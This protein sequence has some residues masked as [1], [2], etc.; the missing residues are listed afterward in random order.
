MLV[1]ANMSNGVVHFVVT[2][3]LDA[4]CASVFSIVS[5]PRRR[6][7]WQSSLRSVELQTPGPARLGTRWR[8][9]TRAG[10]GFEMEITE[11]EEPTRWSERGSGRMA[12]AHLQVEFEATPQGTRLRV[13]VDIAFK[14]PF[15][16]LAPVVRRL[17]PGALSADIRR[18]GKLARSAPG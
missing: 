1:V 16:L 18:V 4:S 11:F 7:E 2:E 6:L 5:D 12:D 10:P 15:Q 8:E 3:T 14:G 9:V 13:T 17:M